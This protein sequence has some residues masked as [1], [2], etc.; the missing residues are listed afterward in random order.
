MR[1][2]TS[3]LYSI[4]LAVAAARFNSKFLVYLTNTSA[5]ITWYLLY[6]AL[7]LPDPSYS[8]PI[9]CAWF[10]ALGVLLV[11]VGILFARNEETS[12][13]ATIEYGIGT[14][15][16]SGSALVAL[17]AM[18]IRKIAPITL[19]TWKYKLNMNGMHVMD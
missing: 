9:Y 6:L 11:G 19:K 16:S 3:G 7:K 18:G 5:L 1:T 15:L 14:S 2:V 13:I 10:A 8:L 12:E 17:L 4:C